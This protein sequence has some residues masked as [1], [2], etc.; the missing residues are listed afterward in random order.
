MKFSLSQFNNFG[1][2]MVEK[3]P[4][5]PLKLYIKISL[6]AS[7]ITV[8]MFGVALAFLTV[9]IANL[10]EEKEKELARTQ[11]AEF[12]EHIQ[13]LRTTDTVLLRQSANLISNTQPNLSAV[14]VW[15]YEDGVFSEMIASEDSSPST[16]IS[17]E[18]Q[19][20]LIR[21]E[22]T[23]SIDKNTFRVFSPLRNFNGQLLGAVEI[24]E[25]L[26]S[27][28]T[29]AAGYAESVIGF[30]LLTVTLMI[31]GIYLMF[32]YLVN[33]PITSLLN[34]M[35]QAET[36]NLAVQAD[37]FAED[38]L[39]KVASKFNVMVSSLNEMTAEREKYQENLRL[40]VREATEEL[41]QKNEQLGD[42]NLQLWQMSQKVTAV[43]R[44]ASAGQTA[45]QFAHEVGTPL[46]LISGHIQL[47]RLQEKDAEGSRLEIISNQI[48]RIE[49]I[50]R[51][52]LDRTKIS[53]G[54]LETI[55]LNEVLQKTFDAT[56][57]LLDEHKIKF[58]SELQNNLPNISANADY[59][60]QV[61]INLIKNALDANCRELKIESLA[62]DNKVIVTFSDDGSG[63]TKDVKDRIFDV[64]YTT[65]GKSGTGLGLV[66][67][68]QILQEHDAEIEVESQPNIGTKFTLIF[69]IIL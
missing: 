37:I 51:Q 67:V 19:T 59:L 30:T 35:A 34:A 8:L 32:R 1:S 41:R 52:T 14:R 49:R 54:G 29:I 17:R 16:E 39:G 2:T 40:R 44:L 23:E 62:K 46:N 31:L 63:M 43:E 9:K 55:N 7:V 10:V 25:P 69:P 36:G 33:N 50:V 57:P 60:Q 15:K 38:E 22:K 6:A 20:S 5:K 48:E 68:K 21:K 13:G 66:V 24:A 3:K 12:A 45:A 58:I 27:P 18:V 11:A 56:E 4:M 26:D 65:K 47:L 42:A 61:F 64:L 28:W 53:K